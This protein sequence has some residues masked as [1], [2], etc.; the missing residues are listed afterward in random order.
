MRFSSCESAKPDFCCISTFEILGESLLVRGKFLRR[1]PPGINRLSWAYSYSNTETPPDT[2]SYPGP[3]HQI[4]YGSVQ[5]TPTP[6]NSWIKASR[7][8]RP[9]PPP[10]IHQ[11]G[12]QP[13]LAANIEAPQNLEY[14]VEDGLGGS[15]LDSRTPPW[16]SD[17]AWIQ[18]PARVPR[19]M[20]HMIITYPIQILVTVILLV[21]TTYYIWSQLSQG[22]LPLLLLM[23]G[24]FVVI[25]LN[26][27]V[28]S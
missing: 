17:N 28:R 11:Y 19:W 8:S 10:K 5:P 25:F 21:G 26:I 24:P 16:E 22:R 2:P 15:D 7:Q 27:Y 18:I 12:T 23:I 13:I 9:Y 1:S 14:N 6:P 4:S 20:W 3:A